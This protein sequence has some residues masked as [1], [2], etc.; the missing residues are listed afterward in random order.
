MC[1]VDELDV[2]ELLALVRRAAPFADAAAVGA[3]TAVLD[4]L[5]GRYPS[6]DFAELR[7]RVVWDRVT[8]TL[9]GRPGAQRLAVTS[10]GTIP[11]R[12]LFGV[13]LGRRA[14]GPRGSASSTRRWSTSPASATSSRSAPRSWRIEEIT[15][16]RVLVTPAPGRA[17]AAA[18]LARRRARPAGRAGP[19]AGRVR[20][21]ARCRPRGRAH[22]LAAAGLDDWARATCWPTWASSGRRPGT[23]PTTARIV[24]ERFRDEL[25]DWRVVLH[26][27]FGAQVH[28]PWALAI[29]GPAARALRRRRAGD[30]RRRRHRAAAARHRAR[31]R[32]GPRRRSR[33]VAAR[34]GRGRGRSSPTEVGGS[35]LFASRFR[36]CAARALLLPR[37]NPGQRSPLW[38]QRQ[39]SAQLLEVAARYG[40]FPIVL[41]TVR[42]CLQD[43]F[44]VPGAR[45]R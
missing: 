24:V 34:P 32:R 4:M 16:D 43:V 37:R 3:S 26:S 17:R 5:A 19:R 9:T 1:A 15:H 8:G 12:G 40:S 33:L 42:E 20:A 28:A 38:Q 11:D 44:D 2:D 22:A 31:R 45:R 23:C 14:S 13:F 30:A 25:G 29:G 6:D 7:P 35:A 27:P 18:V 10:G 39:R 21:R 41:E 36:E